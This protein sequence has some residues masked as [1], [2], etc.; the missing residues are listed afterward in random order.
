MPINRGGEFQANKLSI[1]QEDVAVTEY[2]G[3][4][5]P[6]RATL[7]RGIVDRAG[8]GRRRYG[9]LHALPALLVGLL[10]L[11]GCASLSAEE[12]LAADWYTIGVED[13]SRG[14]SVSRI[15]AHRKA[16]A[17]VGVQPDMVRYNEG[18]AFGLQSFCTR[19]RGY[20]EGENGRNYS[21][22]CPRHLEPMFMQGYLAGQ[23]RYRTKQAIRRLERELAKVREE[24]AEIRTS[25][26]QGYTVD[27]KG[28][29]H[30]LN[31]YE[32]D[33]MYER[34]LAL[35]REEGRLEGEISTLRT[36]LAGA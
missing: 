26:D 8:G 18:R 23:D 22:V 7:L 27:D 20:A 35:G 33:A 28:H 1:Q 34:L 6:S 11:S 24:V 14:Q 15:G 25:L 3:V 29:K 19:E 17:E 2:P 13:G 10:A 30:T 5:D 21:G 16:C 36:S 9:A 32:R 31:K 4:K 12:C